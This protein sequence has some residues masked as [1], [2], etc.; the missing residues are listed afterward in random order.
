MIEQKLK[1]QILDANNI[2]DVIGQFVTLRK[3]GINYLGICPFHPDRHPSMTVSPSRQT[4]KCF[5]CGKGGDAIQFMM[6]YE[7][8]SFNEAITWLANRV[9]I[10]LPKPVMS[11]DEVNKAKEREAQRIAISAAAE[12]FERHLPDAKAYL[13][14]RGYD[15]SN[16][17]LHDFRVGYAPDGNQAKKEL[18][19]AGY[20]ERKLIE[21]D[22]LK[23]SD[24]GFVYDT[25]KDRI[26]FPFLD[27]KGN[28][29]GYS[30]R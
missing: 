19:S 4:Y 18:L 10:E 22:V 29:I 21:V 26:M 6:D 5:V 24:K 16:K 9:G 8:M 11:D 23:E 28:I 25:F 14:S 30:G 27:L 2:V 17:I 15:L 20:S 13:A 7:S 12:F 1:E 3:K